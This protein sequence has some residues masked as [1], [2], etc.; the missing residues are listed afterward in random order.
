MHKPHVRAETQHSTALLFRWSWIL[1]LFV[2]AV[3]AAPQ[4]QASVNPQQLIE[5]TAT[6]VLT[7]LETEPELRSDPQR[8]Y[9]MV[10]SVLLTHMDFERM[11]R[12][13]LGKHWKRASDEQRAQFVAEFQAL[14][15]RTYATAL[16]S[17]SGQHVKYYPVNYAPDDKTVTVKTEIEQTSGP[18]IPVSYSLYQKDGEWKAYDVV[19]DG[20]S[21]VAN[22]RASFGAE[23][24][25]RGLDALIE[26]LAARN[27]TASQAETL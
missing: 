24:R 15:V 8:L 10:N 19:I 14:L 5:Q 12:W 23:V 7:S 11:A 2:A 1:A 26:S 22:Y 16:A 27:Q 13:V 18:A 25:N 21:M 6:R 9:D 17:Y 20:I 4:S 3:L